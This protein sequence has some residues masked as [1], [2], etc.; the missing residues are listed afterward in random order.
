MEQY[1]TFFRPGHG[2]RHGKGALSELLPKRWE[3]RRQ[4]LLEQIESM[5]PDVLSLVA[6]AVCERAWCSLQPQVELDDHGFFAECLCD[7]WD[8]SPEPSRPPSPTEG[9]YRAAIA[10]LLT[11]AGLSFPQT[12]EG[13]VR[14]RLRHL[15]AEVEVRV[16]RLG[17]A[18]NM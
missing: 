12:A 15:L 8:P 16:S 18:P 10:V 5:D 7:E 11:W 13:L 1:D 17:G 4:K 14:R 6:A 3:F 9:P 2:R